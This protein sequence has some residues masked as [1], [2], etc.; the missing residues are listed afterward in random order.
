MEAP[1]SKFLRPPFL[2]NQQKKKVK[3][4]AGN[5]I[6]GRNGPLYIFCHLKKRISHWKDANF[7][8]W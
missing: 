2:K 6:F 4:T 8:V 3:S 5:E 7:K 1:V